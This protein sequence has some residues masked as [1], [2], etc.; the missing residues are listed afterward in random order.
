MGV[1]DR[2]AR[3][4]EERLLGR[5]HPMRL[6]PAEPEPPLRRRD[7][8]G[9]PSGA[10]SPRPRRVGD[11]GQRGRLG[12]VEVVA[13]DDRPLDDDLADLAVGDEQVVGPSAIGSSRDPDDLDP[14]PVDRPADADARAPV[15]LVA[16]LAQD[17]VAADRGDRQ[18]LGR[19]V[20]REDLDAGRRAARRTSPA[21]RPAPAHPAEIDPPQRR[22][23]A[24]RVRRRPRRRGGARPASR[25]GSSRRSPRSPRR[26]FADRPAPAGSRP[27]RGR[28]PSSPARGRR[29]RRAGTCRGRS[30]PARSR[31]GRGGS[32]TCASKI[33]WV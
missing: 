33:A 22:Q 28:S 11:L 32:S 19:P 18:R 21:P 27:S 26:S 29:G 3:D 17:L 24:C 31:R 10:R 12:A 23:L 16:G 1:E 2:L 25:T 13:G 30:R 8:R 4:R 5:D 14:H 7:S 20:G 15:G 9:R 6:P